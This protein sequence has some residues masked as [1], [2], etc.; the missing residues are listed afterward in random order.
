[1]LDENQIILRDFLTVS[2]KNLKGENY[3]NGFPYK[4][5]VNG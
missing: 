1:M 2:G 5:L 4:L 3:V